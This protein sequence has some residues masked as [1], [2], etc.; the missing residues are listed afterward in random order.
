[1]VNQS[2]KLISIVVPVLNEQ[3]NIFPFYESIKKIMQQCEHKYNFEILF[4]DNHSTDLTFEKLTELSFLDPRVRVLRFSRNYGYQ[5][6]ILTGYIHSQGDAVIQLDCDLQDPPELILDFLKYWENGYAVV[7]GVRL[8]TSDNI[9]MYMARKLFYRLVN[10]LS[11]DNLPLNAGDFRLVDRKII[12]ILKQIDDAQ[13][14]LRGTIANIGF[15]QHGIPYNRSERKRGK[16]KFH[17]KDLTK[18]ALDGILNHSIVPLRIA[19][20]FGVC[21]SLVTLFLAI[22]YGAG[23]LILHLPWPSGFT[24]LSILTLMGISLNA[25]FL[26]IIG[27]YLGRIYQQVKKTPVVIESSL[28]CISNTLEST[29]NKQNKLSE[30]V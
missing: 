23:K 28:G 22:A 4:T 12:N 16:S 1:M 18:L 25:L 15:K 26:G 27:E 3:L 10:Y 13:P 2:H 30:I 21:S 7:Y 14:Y 8:K 17:L 6:S 29:N 19:S 11:D 9:L 24:T 5:K 20:F